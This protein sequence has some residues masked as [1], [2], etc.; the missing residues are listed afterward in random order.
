MEGCRFLYRGR[1]K[2]GGGRLLLIGRM[3]QAAVMWKVQE[4][5]EAG[6][7]TVP[8]RRGRGQVKVPYRGRGPRG[9]GVVALP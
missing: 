1:G 4:G 5:K 7:C 2:T 8:H 9:G 6:C 3:G